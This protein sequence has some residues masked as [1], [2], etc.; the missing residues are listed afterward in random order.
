V[1]VHFGF[2][3]DKD[4]SGTHKRQ[5]F[6]L[7]S[8]ETAPRAHAGCSELT[9]PRA[10]NLVPDAGLMTPHEDLDGDLSTV[11]TLRQT[12]ITCAEPAVIRSGVMCGKRVP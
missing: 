12:A 3:F 6:R 7:E 8:R 2:S 5:A 11:V 9:L 10:Y 4:V 1:L